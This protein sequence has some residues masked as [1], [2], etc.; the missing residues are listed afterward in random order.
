MT[1]RRA[2][3]LYLPNEDGD[4]QIE[5]NLGQCGPRRALGGLLD[6]GLIE[7]VRIV[8]LLHRVKVGDGPTER[9][10][11]LQIVG[12]FKP[13]IVLLDKPD[14]TG[15]TRLDFRAWRNLAEF[16][17]LLNEADPYHWWFKPL[18]R[19]TRA[20]AAFVDVGFV[21]GS[22]S[23]V[24]LLRRAGVRDVRWMRQSYDPGR[25]GLSPIVSDSIVADVVMSGSRFRS[26][27]APFRGIPGAPDRARAVAALV[28]EFGDALHV[29]GA[30]WDVPGAKG[31]VPY[32]DLEWALRTAWVSANWDHFAYEPDYYSNRLP[33]SLA[34]GT[35]H[36]TT[37]HPGFERQFGELPFLRFVDHPAE[38]APAIKDYLR[39]TPP[40][41][42]LEH[43][44][45]GRTFAEANL[46]QDECVTELLNAA[47]AGIDL[48]AARSVFR[49]GSR[50]LTEE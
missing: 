39:S 20:A 32:D 24:R 19:E 50:M 40:E 38:L 7:A 35:V 36:F 30:G 12:D 42:R 33:I 1:G 49:G 25:F 15:L 29:Y 28:S 2:R 16:K 26:R 14:G 22:G 11:V 44:R 23:F 21:V 5:R 31:L 10:R 47:G 37:R 13:T 17:F 6:A 46:R 3:V 34:I 18:S 48:T 41:T 8:S 45:Q 43:A 4:H 9:A 27:Y